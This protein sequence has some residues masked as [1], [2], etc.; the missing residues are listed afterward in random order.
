[1]ITPQVVNNSDDAR[2][3]TEEYKRQFQ[4][5]APLRSEMTSKSLKSEQ[6]KQ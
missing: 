5:L 6:P 2:E 4:S 1:L 3:M